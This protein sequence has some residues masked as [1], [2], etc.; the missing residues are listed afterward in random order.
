MKRIEVIHNG[1][2]KSIPENEARVLLLLKKA[3]LAPVDQPAPIR[4]PAPVAAPKVEASGGV[5]H[6]I[7]T[8]YVD[9]D[10]WHSREEPGLVT[11]TLVEPV[12]VTELQD[13]SPRFIEGAASEAPP[14]EPEAPAAEVSERTGKPKRVY[15]RRDMRAEGTE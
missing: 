8:S 9:A 3:T 14:A 2:R 12:E 1:K 13:A 11:P 6:M 15:R 4:W 5:T 7:D 10:G